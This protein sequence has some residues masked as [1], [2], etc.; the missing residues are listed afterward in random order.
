[1]KR[2]L[3]FF[4]LASLSVS[5]T[6]KNMTTDTVSVQQSAQQNVTTFMGI[7][8]E[9]EE[10]AMR[11]KLQAK[12]FSESDK[13]ILKG[14]VEGKQ[15]FLLIKTN[16][17]SVSQLIVVEEDTIS[18]VKAAVDKFNALIETYRN[19]EKR[20]AEYEYNYPIP[21]RDEE[22]NKS[23]IND[24]YYYAEF[25]QACEPQN[26]SRRISLRLSDEYGGYR[27]VTTYDNVY[28]MD[29]TCQIWDIK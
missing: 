13:D 18:N 1:M 23:H 14:E 3:Q 12:G 8:V 17:D 25:F 2:L 5:A 7:P 11:S 6:A 20:Y 27:I 28:N 29:E 22:T 9:G 15:C 16:K 21:D 24:G 10:K 26:Y 19:D 4:V